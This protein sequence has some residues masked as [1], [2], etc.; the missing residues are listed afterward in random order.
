MA[1]N[2][3]RTYMCTCAL[4]EENTAPFTQLALM[5]WRDGPKQSL[6][7]LRE[8][9]RTH[10]KSLYSATDTTAYKSLAHVHFTT[11]EPQR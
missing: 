3:Q 5:A 6:L 11:C 7:W 9:V 4:G 10:T 8:S 1:C 2:M